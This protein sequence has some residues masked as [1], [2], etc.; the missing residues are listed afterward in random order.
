MF[1]RSYVTVLLPAVMLLGGCI[2]TPPK[3][4]P[5]PADVIVHVPFDATWQR[6]IAFFANDN[7]QIQT[8][9]KASGLVASQQS[10]L[11]RD[12]AVTWVDAGTAL[13]GPRTRLLVVTASFNVFVRPLGDSTSVRVNFAP[14]CGSVPCVSTGVFETALIKYVQTP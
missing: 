13:G 5:A 3:T 9:D 1:R 4:H 12:Q 11:T 8:I 14:R 6:I 7:I 2:A 10:A